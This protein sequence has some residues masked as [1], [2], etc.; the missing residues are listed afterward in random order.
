MNVGVNEFRVLLIDDDEDEHFFIRDL[1]SDIKNS[2]FKLDWKSS[3]QKGLDALQ[4]EKYDV[5]LL[6]FRLGEFTG[7]DLL[8]KAQEL[9]IECP[10]VILTGQGDFET[11]LQ[12]MQIGAAEYLIKGQLTSPLLERTLRYTIKHALDVEHLKDQK[13]KYKKL[14]EERTEMEAQIL[15]QDRMASVGLLASSLAHEIG[16]PMGI[17]RSRAE[18]AK[19]KASGNESLQQDMEIIV[20]QIDRISK[21]VNSLLNLARS[22]PSDHAVSVSIEAVVNDVLNLLKPELDHKNIALEAHLIEETFVK[23]EAG[24]LGQVLLNLLVNAVHAIEEAKEKGRPDHHQIKITMHEN[25]SQ[26]DLLISDTGTGI[27]PENVN[28]IFKP[29]FTT[30]AIGQGT[31]MGLSTS[32]KLVQSWGGNIQVQETSL[33]GTIF[34][35]S[36]IKVS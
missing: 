3:Y 18:F 20:K 36:L 15:M 33:N 24:P 12:A 29:F 4:T 8:K 25:K 16:T 27:S 5:C 21:L 19:K 13:E 26:I 31:G 28:E 14:L 34:K 7:I 10:I 30:K 6:D 11:D 23:S 1:L 35:V 9:K 17:I 32:Y 2:D 22:K